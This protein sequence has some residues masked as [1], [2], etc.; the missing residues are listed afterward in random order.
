MRNKSIGMLLAAAAACGIYKY[1]KMSP[2]QRSDLMTKGRDI[3][4]RKLGLG[5]IFGK[6]PAYSAPNNNSF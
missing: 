3:L 4:D 6:K 2:E 5:N 1:K